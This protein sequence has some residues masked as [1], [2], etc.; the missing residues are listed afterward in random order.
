MHAVKTA[1]KAYNKFVL[2]AVRWFKTLKRFSKK[3]SV[4]MWIWKNTGLNCD[5]FVALS[6]S[7]K[8]NW[9][10]IMILSKTT[11]LKYAENIY[12]TELF[13]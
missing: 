2:F 9:L 13:T 4:N 3:K 1:N 10:R 8:N 7:K 11:S 12:S 5:H 6:D